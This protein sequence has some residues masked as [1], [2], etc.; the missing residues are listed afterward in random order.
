M[1]ICIFTRPAGH[2]AVHAEAFRD[3]LKR[4]GVNAQM[5]TINTVVECDLAVFWGHRRRDIIAR[6]KAIGG[7]Y[8]VMERGYLGDRFV[9]TS[10]GYDGLNGRAEFC[11]G[12]ASPDRWE[13]HF[14]HLMQPWRRRDGYALVMGQVL[15]DASLE[16]ANYPRWV[17]ETVSDLK[18]R[19]WSVMFRAHPKD[20][21]QRHGCSTIAGSLSDAL[22]G[23]A[24]V[25][26][27]NSNS[28]VDAALAG[29][30]VVTCDRGSMAWEVAAHDLGDAGITPDREAW[31][32]RL[33]W[34]Q[35]RIDEIRDGT[36]W[37]YLKHG[38]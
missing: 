23:A 9:W 24:F 31:A 21:G 20:T 32:H 15:G 22:D 25:V 30:P 4:H 6:Q 18:A 10:L 7:R 17:A 5:E 8:L 26:T 38:A 16:G 28:G 12:D 36:A 34:K 2:Q 29:V 19:G 27:W 35:W 14:A 37:E 3:G 11:V 13:Q 33:A 1:R